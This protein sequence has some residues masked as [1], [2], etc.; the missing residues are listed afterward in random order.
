MCYITTIL[1]D[2]QVVPNGVDTEVLGMLVLSVTTGIDPYIPN[3]QHIQ[4]LPINRTM[5]PNELN[6]IGFVK[7]VISLCVSLIFCSDV[8]FSI[9]L[10]SCPIH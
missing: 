6:I 2:E 7:T 1:I 8:T 10:Q 9:L 3:F 4:L 5:K